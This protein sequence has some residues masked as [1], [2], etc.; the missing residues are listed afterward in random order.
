MRIEP[1]SESL[2]DESLTGGENYLAQNACFLRAVPAVYSAP[3]PHPFRHP[4]QATGWLI[5]TLFGIV[6]LILLLAVI[7]AIP[8]VNFLA[9]GYLLEVE[10]RVARTGRLRDAFPLL[11]VAPR[12]GTILLGVWLWVLP[13][14]F[15][16]SF[17]SDATLIDPGGKSASF[18][19]G[20]I[21]CVSLLITLHLFLALLRGGGF[22]CFFRPIKNIRSLI[23]RINEGNLLLSAE[24]QTREFISRL[25]LKHHFVLGFQG[26]VGAAIWL[27]IPTL[28]LA[29]AVKQQG[30]LISISVIGGVLLSIVLAW[31]PFLQ[32]RFAA[33]NRFGAFFELRAIRHAFKQS[34]LWWMVAIVFVYLLALPLYLFKA[35]APPRD[36]MWLVTVVFIMMIYPAK[37]LLGWVYYRATIKKEKRAWWGARWMA[38]IIFIPLLMLYVFVLFFMPAIGE[39]GRLVL[40]EHH[41]FLLPVPFW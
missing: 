16:A 21:F 41:A 14:R 13:I 12:I 35:V 4:L 18:L 39:H 27:F 23:T 40:F 17:A 25:Q 36:A 9:L 8:I 31:L 22:W 10:G 5:R 37:V 2:P 7:A 15:L 20:L 1:S 26:F 28:L 6:S 33:E 29:A 34:P 38:R 30:G 19:S 3:F 24:V 11:E 32:T